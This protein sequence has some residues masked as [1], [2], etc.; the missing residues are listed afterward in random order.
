MSWL[1]V[2]IAFTVAAIS[3]KH[4]LTSQN[5]DQERVRKHLENSLLVQHFDNQ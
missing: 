3:L 4:T 1:V 5:I 2:C